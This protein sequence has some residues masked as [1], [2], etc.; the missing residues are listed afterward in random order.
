MRGWVDSV[1]V[2]VL[3][4]YSWVCWGCIREWVGGVFVGGLGVYSWVGW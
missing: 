2:G 4:V 3:V 1:C